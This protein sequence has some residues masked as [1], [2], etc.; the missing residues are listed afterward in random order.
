M[1]QKK[2]KFILLFSL[3]TFHFS[4]FASTLHLSISANPSR[5]N[6]LIATDGTSHEISSWIF[7]SL[8]KYD[9]DA[10][11]TPHL[12]KSYRFIDDTTLEFELKKGI[13]W[14]DGKEFTSQDIIF[15][16]QTIIS[17]KIFTPYSS[18]FRY[19]KSVEMSGKYKILVKYKEPYFKALEIWM[20]DI[21]PHH[22]LKDDKDLMTSKFNKHPIGIGSYT[23][24]G[25]TPSNDINL[26]AN[27]SYFKHKPLID[28]ITYHFIPDPSTEFLTLKTK[29]LDIGSLTPMQYER[30][31]D[32]DFKKHFKILEKM[33]QGYTYLGFNLRDKKFKN[34]KIR[35]ALSLAID[36]QELVD[37]LFLGHGQICNGPFMPKTF[38]YPTDLKTQNP[39]LQKAKKLLKEA[40][41]GKNNPFAFELVTNSNNS[42]RVYTAQVI[43]HQL[44]K[45]G[46]KMKIIVMEWQGFL[47]TVVMPKKFETVLLGWGL[48]LMPD[49]YSIWHSESDKKGGFNFVGY[50]NQKVDELI[51]KG[52][53]T[54]DKK[55]LGEI[56]REI[57]KLI[58]ADNPYLFLYIPNSITVVNKKIKN[59]SNSII[60]IRHNTIDWIKE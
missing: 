10:K 40:G 37:I 39:N 3:F 33:S 29:K 4:L 19:V 41:Y 51:K 44:K 60:G 43:Q 18:D 20:M 56:Y 35:E 57:F 50:K 32:D 14:S 27:K 46:V 48:G 54:I 13:L 2:I 38:A 17:P 23:I 47:N 15:T 16:Y 30:Q 45:I 58:R 31:I 55:K 59:V 25:F 8:V 12:A 22:I 34:P 21:L 52:E 26:F 6:P 24:K 53:K 7:S 36:R 5:L 1:F 28:K 49:A 42:T 11:V 9:K